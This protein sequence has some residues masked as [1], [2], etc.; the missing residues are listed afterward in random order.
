MNKTK[1]ICTLGPASDNKETLTALINNGLNVARLNLSHGNQ[2]YLLKNI[3]LIKEVREQLNHP[4][5][6]LMDTR[7]PEIRTKTF[8][9]GGVDLFAGEVIRL[10]IGDFEGTAEKFC[11]TYEHLY[12]D[13]KLGSSILI[14]DGL[15]E[16]EVTEIEDTDIIC[17]V[18]NGGRVKN[19]K[20]INVPGVDVK[21]PALTEAD[22]N[23]IIFGIKE[24]IDYLAASFIRSKR[25]V[26]EIRA[27]LDQNG[28]EHIHIISKIESQTGVDNIDE[29]IEVSNGIMVARGDL[30][31]ETPAE[32][33]PQIQKKIIHKCNAAGIPVIT[34]TQMLDS[35]IVNP[36][37]TRAEVSDVANA[38]LDGTDVIML[39]G[40]TAAGS[41][42]V[43]SIKIMRKIAE[44]SEETADYEAVYKRITEVLDKSVTN[45]VSYATCTTAMNLSAAAII[46]PTYSGKTARLISMFRPESPIIAPTINP[47]TQR[48]LNMLW[49]VIPIIMKAENSSDILFYKSIEHAKSL[50]FAKNGDT[51]VITA[52]IP[53][54]TKGN[55]NLMKVME[56]E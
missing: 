16:V 4:I 51:V 5:A 26:E 29:I 20:G 39:S 1:I 33:I 32:Y 21:L 38:I 52:G 10:C 50:G 27:L 35:M 40:E 48:Q 13:V 30:G 12:K 6:I 8:K 36:R 47:I 18:K 42:P 9:D 11:I 24:G 55:T 15:I 46:C 17:V 28:G 7:G 43:E 56:V 49:G 34:A 54:N 19:R 41:Y 44:A 23:D 22:A 14:D 45:A 37:P 3:N 25:D 31:V 2:E 53:L